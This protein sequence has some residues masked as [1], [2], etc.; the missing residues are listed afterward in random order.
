MST[1]EVA[2]LLAAL[3][4]GDLSLSEVAEDGHYHVEYAGGQTPDYKITV[5]D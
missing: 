3:R 4:A 2:D 1:G 5:F